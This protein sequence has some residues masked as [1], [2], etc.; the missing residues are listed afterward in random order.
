MALSTELKVGALFFVGLGLALWF[1]LQ[2]SRAA[3]GSGDF[4]L[5][6][7]RVAKLAPG[8]PVLYNGVKVGKIAAVQP[9]LVNGEPR[10]RVGFTVDGP[11]R[12]AVLIGPESEARITQ[13]LL[14][15]PALELVAQGGEPLSNE[16][17]KLVRISDPASLDEVL[18]AIQTVIEENRAELKAV[19]ASARGTL[20]RLGEASAQLRDAVAENR[21]NLKS[22]IANAERMTRE[23]GDLVAENRAAVRA[24]I[25]RI[26]AAAD[27]IARLVEENRADVR[28]AI[29][30][31]PR[32]IE[33]FSQAA[34]EIRDTVA[35]N[36]AD[37]RTAVQNIASFSPK[38]DRIGDHLE[39]ATAQIAAGKGTLGK[40]VM[41]D[42]LHQQASSVLRKAEERLE[43]VKPF[44][45][46]I[47][48]LKFY[49]GLEAGSNVTSGA[50]RGE[51]YL[52]LE[53]QPWKFW[54][55]GVS[56]R[57]AEEERR[58][59]S[60]DPDKIPVD[61]NALFGWRWWPDD[62]IER[63]R[64][65]LAG[66]LID[67]KLGVMIDLALS[68]RFDL[69]GIAR[70][71]DSERQ[72]DDRRY[73]EGDVRVRAT[74]SWRVFER[75]WLIVGGDDLVDRPGVFLALRGEL[76]DADLRNALTAM[77]FAQ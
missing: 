26:E 29:E 65:S 10:V 6:F 76:L 47:S 30:R 53:P 4:T 68:E 42:T 52:R 9:V 67:S 14:G 11:M 16:R 37:I 40:L 17:L 5:H 71:K 27:Q 63:Y 50:S 51:A 49:A 69:R 56:Y 55:L 1:T 62:D 19:I 32:A 66:G 23:I 13:G 20:E 45:Q 43:E 54:H 59:R 22:A 34:A 18:R 25:A 60:D 12:S 48:Q 70:L 36:R 39:T 38:L 64:L 41:E 24:M 7:R 15:G 44:T 33:N 72:P 35:E 75:W 31:L 2:T 46:G 74:L 61:I 77:S 3:N 21:E 28:A 8:D 58:V 73:E 57:T